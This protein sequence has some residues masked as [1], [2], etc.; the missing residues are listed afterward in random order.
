[1][2]NLYELVSQ[3]KQN[4]V[5]MQEVINT[6]QPKI[7]KVLHSTNSKQRE[8]LEQELTYKL[9]TCIKKYDIESTP[10]FWDMVEIYN[11]KVV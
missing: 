10:G 8:D 11:Q 9:I 5:A 3:S 6:F 1:M 4:Q 2:K 7:K